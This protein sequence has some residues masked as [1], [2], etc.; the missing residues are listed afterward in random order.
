MDAESVAVAE[1]DEYTWVQ[2]TF[3]SLRHREYRLLWFGSLFS[4]AALWIQQTTINWLTY[5]VTGSAF[6]LG[7]VN[8]IRS[9]PLLFLAPFGGLAADRLDKKKLMFVTQM[10]L[11]AVTAAFATVVLLDYAAVWNIILFSVLTGI[12][13]ALNMPV[14]QAIVPK[15]V[16]REDLQN[17]I[18]LN[19]AG[20]NITR[21]VGPSI[22][23]LLIATVGMWGNFYIQTVMYLGVAAMVWQLQ[24]VDDRDQRANKKGVGGSLLEGARYVWKNKGLRLQMTVALLPVLLALPYITLMPVIARDELDVK[25]RGF[26]F[27]M[28][29]PGIGAVTGTLLVASMGNIQRRGLLIFLCLIGLGNSLIA[30][31]LSNHYSVTF[32]LL[33]LAGAFQ[34]V[35]MSQNQTMLQLKTPDEFRGRVMGIFMLNQGLMPLG[36]IAA[37]VLAEYQGAPFAIAA[38]GIALVVLSVIALATLK[39]MREA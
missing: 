18:A 30:V 5:Q 23:G 8:G 7:A 19:A 26:G 36:S 29:A 16:P 22:G 24:I 27:L 14:R 11:M 2:K 10:F 38:M 25:A 9:L 1:A 32:S 21:V 13:W 20:F 34:M 39:T 28:S 12:G 17:A 3:W 35:Y 31:A 6:M 15:L 33:I 4:S 37:G